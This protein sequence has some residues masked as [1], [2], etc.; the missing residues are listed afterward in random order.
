MADIEFFRGDSKRLKF[1]R[2]D[3]HGDPILLTPSAMY[4]TVK[5]NC[6]TKEFIFQKK[7]SDM[8]LG[9]DGY[10]HFTINPSDTETVP[11]ETYAYDLEVTV[12]GFVNT[13][14]SGS[15]KI[16]KESTWKANKS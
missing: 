8:T 3:A 6:D 11:Y 13:I 2:L 4:F 5:R 15:L 14:S 12:E 10:W 16:K 9:D 7:L 1:Q